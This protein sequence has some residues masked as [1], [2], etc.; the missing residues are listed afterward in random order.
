VHPV[1]DAS[2]AIV[3]GLT[4]GSASFLRAVH[5]EED[6]LFPFSTRL[7]R[8]RYVN[9]FDH[10][11]TLR[12]TINTFLGLREAVQAGEANEWSELY[13][14]Q[15]QRFLDCHRRRITNPADLGLLALLL[16]GDDNGDAT[17]ETVDLLEGIVRRGRPERLV[18]QDLCWMLWGAVALAQADV[19]KAAKIAGAVFDILD[20]HL[21]QPRTLLPRHSTARHRRDLVS[22]GGIVYFLRASFEYARF[23]DDARAWTLFER[24]VRAML[25]IQGPDGEWPWLISV[26][27]GRPLDFYPVFAVHQDSMAMLFLLPAADT[28]FRDVDA[29]IGRSLRWVE[30]ANESGERMYLEHPFLAYRSIR[31][32][33]ALLKPRR[34]VRALGN[35]IRGRAGSLA[36]PGNVTINKECRSYHLGWILY[37]WSGRQI[38]AGLSALEAAGRT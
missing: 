13:P 8:G 22:F 34:Y 9:E 15:L 24:G 18:L 23:A 1:A 21:V 38:G 27:S 17:R 19:P 3:E 14:Q 29:A 7:I 12:Y 11:H 6:G 37:A 35:S 16:A 26:R 20:E 2:A 28:G 32:E 10:E 30:G 36:G 4:R 25:A 33:Q 5:R 31:R